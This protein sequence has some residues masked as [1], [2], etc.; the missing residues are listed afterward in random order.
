MFQVLT[1]EEFYCITHANIII[2][3]LKKNMRH[4]GTPISQYGGN[5]GILARIAC[6]ILFL[7]SNVFFLALSK[8]LISKAY[9]SLDY[10]QNYKLT[11][12]GTIGTLFSLMFLRKL[13][14]YDYKLS[15][16]VIFNLF[17]LA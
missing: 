16:I 2:W 8:P 7:A 15:K 4:I 9:Y 10:Y 12:I 11:N 6:F 17:F 14:L 3:R 1:K 5:H 13:T